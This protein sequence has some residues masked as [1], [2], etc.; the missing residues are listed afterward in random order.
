[1]YPR[2]K[3]NAHKSTQIGQMTIEYVVACLVVLA[4]L[5]VMNL[6]FGEKDESMIDKFL[7][8]V[9]EAYDDL[10]SFMSIPI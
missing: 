8:S 6:G 4:L 2:N 10:S 3:K 7:E 9:E 1:M 5:G